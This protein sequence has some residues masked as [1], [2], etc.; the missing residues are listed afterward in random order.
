MLIRVTHE[1][2]YD[3]DNSDFMKEFVEY[4]DDYA[5]T[6]PALEAFIVDRFINPNFDSNGH[7]EIEIING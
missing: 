5:L 3:T 6:L 1:V 4:Q 7:T 2:I